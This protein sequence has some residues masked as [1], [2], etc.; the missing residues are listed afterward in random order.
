MAVGILIDTFVVRSLLVP[1]LVALFGRLSWW[2]RTAA[3][4]PETRA[5]SREPL[6]SEA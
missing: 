5:A 2:P 1:S 3:A 6:R 4:P